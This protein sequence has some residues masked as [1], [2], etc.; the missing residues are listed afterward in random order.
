MA[1]L[2][3]RYELPRG[4]LALMPRKSMEKPARLVYAARKAWTFLLID[5]EESGREWRAVQLTSPF[6][7]NEIAMRGNSYAWRT[8]HDFHRSFDRAVEM[9]M[10][11]ALVM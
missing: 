11:W 2:H 3:E 4:E 7:R 10:Y 6:S 8:Y 9:G 1:K 5:L